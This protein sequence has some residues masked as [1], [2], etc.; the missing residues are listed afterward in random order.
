MSRSVAILLFL[1]GTTWVAETTTREEIAIELTRES[2][3]NDGISVVHVNRDADDSAL[4][5][6]VSASLNHDPNSTLK[7]QAIMGLDRAP[8]EV[9]LL[10]EDVILLILPRLA[11]GEEEFDKVDLNSM[12]EY[13][14][15]LIKD[16]IKRR[17]VISLGEEHYVSDEDMFWLQQMYELRLK[18][19]LIRQS[20]VVEDAYDLIEYQ[21]GQAEMRCSSLLI[22]ECPEKSLS[23]STIRVAYDFWY[24]ITYKDKDGD[25]V[26]FHH[27]VVKIIAQRLNLTI[28]MIY[29]DQP[30][31]WGNKVNGSW[32]G[33]FG[34]IEK[35]K[36]DLVASGLGPTAERLESF[37]LS[38]TVSSVGVGLFTKRPDGA[39]ISTENYL[40]EFDRYIWICILIFIPSLILFLVFV[41]M[42]NKDEKFLTLPVAIVLRALNSKGTPGANSRKLSFR[43]LFLVVLLFTTVLNIS[44]RSCLN[45]FLAVK[46]PIQRITNM[47]DVLE[48]TNGVSM[49]AGGELE[50]MFSI[51]PEGSATKKLYEKFKKDPTASIRGYDD[52]LRKVVDH[53]YVMLGSQE[54]ITVLPS[55]TCDI[56]QVKPYRFYYTFLVMAFEKN[57][58]FSR[59]FNLE[60]LK[61][62][63]EGVIDRLTDWYIN[64]NSRKDSECEDEM[65][66]ALSFLNVFTPFAILASGVIISFL[67]T[68]IEFGLGSN[69]S[70]KRTLRD[71]EHEYTSQNDLLMAK[72]TDI[73]NGPNVTNAEKIWLLRKL[74]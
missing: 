17:V 34:M 27:D 51:A 2:Y 3:A 40:W 58:K 4:D 72:A 68:L 39:K 67:L 30:G 26:G 19:S 54:T 41:M 37:D 56:L 47:D 63:G 60:I 64:R 11:H 23:G 9:T 46:I 21:F 33:L 13:I 50:N 36:A 1:F 7:F 55:Y 5:G 43:V 25:I 73:V 16:N 35:G 22:T 71:V 59:A 70:A 28:E 42:A 31:V 15:F 24:P 69:S 10:E 53:D 32:T 74:L 12:L 61:L 49:W 65:V 6:L 66:T 29:N 8:E 62:K 45:S 14:L 44:Y 48:K 20:N 18:L 57:S 52:G 38:V